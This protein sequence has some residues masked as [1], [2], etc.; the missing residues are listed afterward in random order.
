VAKKVFFSFHYKPDNWRASQVRNA[1]MVEGNQPVSDNSWETIT[2]GGDAAIKRWI[3]GQMSGRACAVVLIGS[4]TAERKWINYEIA[5]A[6]NDKRGVVG[7]YI[8]SLQDVYQRQSSKGRNPLD[9]LTLENG[10]RKLSSIVKA[11]DHP[12][13]TSTNVYAYIKSNI[14]TW[15]DEAIKIRSNV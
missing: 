12:Y 8:H 7:I 2:Q 1:G 11:Y 4:A 13:T 3:D 6:W 15:V 9:Y 5:K 14:A 10:A